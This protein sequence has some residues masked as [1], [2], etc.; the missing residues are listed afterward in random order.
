M[1]WNDGD[2]FNNRKCL[3]FFNLNFILI[4]EAILITNFAFATSAAENVAKQQRGKKQESPKA[5]VSK[6]F[7]KLAFES[8]IVT[9]CV[10]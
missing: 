9:N 10:N 3:V 5:S 2:D 4:N 7:Q 1:P 8:S 6:N